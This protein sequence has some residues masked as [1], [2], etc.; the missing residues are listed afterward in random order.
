MA[1]LSEESL[2]ALD[3]EVLR[4]VIR[5]RTHHTLEIPLYQTLR[6]ERKI[7]PE[8]GDTVKKLLK[9]WETHHV[10]DECPDIQYVN[11]LLQITESLKQ[12]KK[13]DTGTKPISALSENDLKTI[14]NLLTTRRS[15]RAWTDKDI[16]RWMLDKIM[17]AGLQAP[18][19]CN[20]QSIKFLLVTDNKGLDVFAKSETRGGRVRIVICQDMRGY[21][22]YPQSIPEYNSYLDCGAATQN[23]LLVAHALG[24]GAVWLTFRPTEIEALRQLYHIPQHTRLTTYMAIGWPAESP[25]TPARKTIKDATITTNTK[26]SK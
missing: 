9:I 26:D 4:A 3:K 21:E 24:L 17:E 7:N 25:M 14:E 8:L 10:T 2:A 22:L 16:P 12:G 23:M 5:E 13:V 19:A 20:L 11:K 6:G 18:H 15:I 1:K